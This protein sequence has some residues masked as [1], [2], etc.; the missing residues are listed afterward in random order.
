M[1]LAA[2][3]L[4]ISSSPLIAQS[5]GAS[6]GPA[7]EAHQMSVMQAIG[8]V[9][10][11]SRQP[12][13]LVLGRDYKRLCR[14]GVDFDLEGVAAPEALQKL[15]ELSGYTL[16]QDGAVVL[17]IAPDTE[18][19]Q[20]D[21][22]THQFSNFGHFTNATMVYL[23]ANL[24]GWIWAEVGHAQGYGGSIMHS[25]SDQEFS[26][27]VAGPA[28]T[29][30]IADRIVQL[31]EHGIWMLRRDKADA[32]GPLDEEVQVFSYHDSPGQVKNLSC[33]PD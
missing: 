18:T 8:A 14:L 1:R 30:E 9:G 24:T 21:I 7:P 11:R 28:S 23:G 2:V 26:F 25:T 31:G 33:G 27:S 22:L 10:L 17:L 29:M 6:P 15:A 5:T 32:K 16:Q 13:G 4:L 20:R 12:I 3:L 19:W